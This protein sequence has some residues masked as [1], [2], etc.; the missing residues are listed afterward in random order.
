MTPLLALI[1]IAA[2]IYCAC[3]VIFDVLTMWLWR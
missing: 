1:V 2:L 3:R